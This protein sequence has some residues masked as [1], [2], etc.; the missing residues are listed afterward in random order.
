MK[1]LYK[2]KSNK[3]LTGVIGGVGEYFEVDP[4]II[5][6]GYLVITVFSGFLPGLIAYI[7]ASL[8]VPK[9]N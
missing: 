4:V 3:V 2:S 6:L 8:I 7:F 1:K 9:T 5:R